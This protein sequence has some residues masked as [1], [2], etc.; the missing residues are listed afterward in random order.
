[1]VTFRPFDQGY[2]FIQVTTYGSEAAQLYA[3]VRQLF[4]GDEMVLPDNPELVAQLKK[5]EEFLTEGGKSLVEAKTGHDD[6]AVAA[7]L[8]INQASFIPAEPP[9]QCG[10]VFITKPEELL[11]AAP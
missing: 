2:R 11:T 5:M 1:M 10:G 3:T 9:F 8:A 6:L 4:V 7:C